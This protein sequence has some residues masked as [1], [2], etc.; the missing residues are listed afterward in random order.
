MANES[1]H[2]IYQK[3]NQ[4]QQ[5]DFFL[6]FDIAGEPLKIFYCS[7][8][9]F[10]PYISLFILGVLQM[11]SIIVDAFQGCNYIGGIVE[12]R[13]MAY[14][15]WNRGNLSGEES[16]ARYGKDSREAAVSGHFYFSLS[17]RGELVGLSWDNPEEPC[18]MTAYRFLIKVWI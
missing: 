15:N 5:Q 1:G 4:H 10:K 11:F 14:P 13:R 6:N 12:D 2:G 18:I 17:D 8:A 7:S 9:Y 3:L 16:S